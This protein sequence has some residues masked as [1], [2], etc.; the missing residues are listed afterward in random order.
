MIKEVSLISFIFGDMNILLDWLK[1]LAI[2]IREMITEDDDVPSLVILL[3]LSGTL[4]AILDLEV[5]YIY[6]FFMLI[7]VLIN[8]GD[9]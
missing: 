1:D 2:K 8:I 3:L 7:F 4:F 5:A 9:V 6:S